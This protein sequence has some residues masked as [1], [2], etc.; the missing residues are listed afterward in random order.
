[1]AISIAGKL[2]MKVSEIYSLVIFP[3][4][5][6]GKHAFDVFSKEIF[7]IENLINTLNLDPVVEK[8]VL[9]IIKIRFTPSSVKLMAEFEIKTNSHRGILDIKELL[10]KA[11]S[12]STDEIKLEIVLKATPSYLIH[13]TTSNR[14]KAI[15][16]IEACL[17]FIQENA[18][19]L[20]DG[21]FQ[22]KSF[23]KEDKSKNSEYAEL[24]EMAGEDKRS[25]CEEDNDET[26]GATEDVKFD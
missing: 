8:A 4:Q 24:I 25:F 9:D 18:L 26:M 16:N 20:Q 10:T 14:L 6:S 12:F 3:I 15:Q 1:M 2:K 21:S 19:K 22:L 5:R 23:N 11:K 13:T 7:T 17:D